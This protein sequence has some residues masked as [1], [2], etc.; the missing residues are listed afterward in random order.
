MVNFGASKLGVRGGARGPVASPLDPL[1]QELRANTFIQSPRTQISVPP[2]FN[3]LLTKCI[4]LLQI[5]LQ[6]IPLSLIVI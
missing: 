3:S 5:Q 1:V 2:A 4:V 6:K